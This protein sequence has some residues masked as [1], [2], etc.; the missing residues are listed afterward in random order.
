MTIPSS[1]TSSDDGFRPSDDAFK[2]SCSSYSST[3]SI[4]SVDPE[5]DRRGRRRSRGGHTD[6]EKKALRERL[7]GLYV[8]A[9]Q[10]LKGRK[11]DL[12]DRLTDL[13]A[14]VEPY[15]IYCMSR[16]CNGTIAW[17]LDPSVQDC[18][19]TIMRYVHRWDRKKGTP[20]CFV[21]QTIGTCIIA[22]KEFAKKFLVKRDR[23]RSALE[24]RNDVLRSTRAHMPPF[25]E[26]VC[27]EVAGETLTDRVA[28]GHHYFFSQAQVDEIKSRLRETESREEG[29]YE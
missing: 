22:R 29:R 10:S 26:T 20:V 11:P 16:Q 8:A 27:I 9:W 15:V 14:A 21:N 25:L 18:I 28:R 2:S 1:S 3:T 7:N 4:S 19:G 23:L 12:Q 24:G 17:E 5:F 6:E 13:H